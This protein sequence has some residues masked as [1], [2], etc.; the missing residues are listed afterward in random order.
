LN[1]GVNQGRP[2]S[3]R[4]NWELLKTCAKRAGIDP[5]KYAQSFLR[6]TK[7]LWNIWKHPVMFPQGEELQTYSHGS[8]FDVGN[9]S[10]IEP[11]G[12]ITIL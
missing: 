8:L 7:V 9:S 12:I 2:L 1:R 11:F 4:K 3:Y 6:S 5:V 10:I